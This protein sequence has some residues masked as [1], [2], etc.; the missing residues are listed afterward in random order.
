MLQIIIPATEM[1]DERL[2]QFISTE[3]QILQLEHSLVSLSK[4]E[5]K[6]C[7]AFLSS[8]AKTYEE[9]VDYIKCM[10]ITPNVP[11]EVYNCLTRENVE[12]INKYIEAPMTATHFMENAHNRRSNE[13][14]TS[15]LIYYWMIALNIPF[16]CQTWHLNRLLAL[17]RVCNIKNQPN[18]G[19]RKLSQSD[20][21][22]R[23]AINAARRKQYNTKG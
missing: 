5:S 10:T 13:T 12:Q 6:W 1:Y 15:E 7:K 9:T 2:K 8:R 3:E 16:E 21:S 11:D 18:K 17:V 14:T 4:W 20:I 19:S 22:Q 23:N